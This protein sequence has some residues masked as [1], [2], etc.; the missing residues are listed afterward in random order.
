MDEAKDLNCKI[1]KMTYTVHISKKCLIIQNV[2]TFFPQNYR[3]RNAIETVLYDY[4]YIF[5]LNFSLVNKFD[6]IDSY[7]NSLSLSRNL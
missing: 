4:T 7:C 3:N 1:I 6:F 2:D 5:M